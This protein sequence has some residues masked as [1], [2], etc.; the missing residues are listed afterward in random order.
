MVV[1]PC[2]VFISPI[3]SALRASVATADWAAALEAAA[4]NTNKM[5]IDVTTFKVASGPGLKCGEGRET[6]SIVQKNRAP[7]QGQSFH[8]EAAG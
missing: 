2:A 5:K 6:V 4:N 3:R 7:K 1:M 8:A